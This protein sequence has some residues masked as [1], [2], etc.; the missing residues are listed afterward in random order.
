MTSGML[1]GTWGH[2]ILVTLARMV[3]DI[4]GDEGVGLRDS[5]SQGR[6]WINR[7]GERFYSDV[8]QIGVSYDYGEFII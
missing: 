3:I 7:Q 6:M 5:N 8:H 2:S 1:V 4:F